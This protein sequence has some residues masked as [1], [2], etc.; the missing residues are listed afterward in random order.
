MTMT[1]AEFIVTWTQEKMDEL[2]DAEPYLLE[3]QA[4][5]AGGVWWQNHTD[6][7]RKLSS[8]LSEDDLKLIADWRDNQCK[9]DYLKYA[10]KFFDALA[11]EAGK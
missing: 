9:D 4:S 7:I 3:C 2:L 5:V 10:L 6:T 1:K 11:E 8:E